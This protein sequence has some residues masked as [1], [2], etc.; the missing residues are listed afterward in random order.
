MQAERCRPEN[1]ELQI[2]KSCVVDYRPSG[3]LAVSLERTIGFVFAQ[4]GK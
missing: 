1:Q 4:V 2:D 3:K